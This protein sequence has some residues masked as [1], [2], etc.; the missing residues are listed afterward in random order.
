MSFINKITKKQVF[1][2]KNINSFILTVLISIFKLSIFN[3][4]LF[5]KGL[6]VYIKNV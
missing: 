5:I 1:K 4:K 6:I 3:I 2:N